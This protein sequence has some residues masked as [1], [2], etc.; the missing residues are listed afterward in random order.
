MAV[1]RD[2]ADPRWEDARLET[3]HEAPTGV[4]H[5]HIGP[6]KIGG[7]AER[8]LDLPASRNVRRDDD[9]SASAECRSARCFAEYVL[10]AEAVYRDQAIARER[11]SLGIDI[12]TS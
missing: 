5:G 8:H 6:E 10:L 1:P 9:R 2:G 12:L 4:E 3:A 11:A 7:D